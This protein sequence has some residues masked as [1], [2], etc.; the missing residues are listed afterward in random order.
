MTHREIGA[1][2]GFALLGAVFV[3]QMALAAGNQIPTA[4]NQRAAYCAAHPADCQ[5]STAGQPCPRDFVR[6]VNGACVPLTVCPPG[7]IPDQSGKC[8]AR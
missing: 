8:V 5:L 2:I 6:A 3:A 1:A 7:Q 4:Q